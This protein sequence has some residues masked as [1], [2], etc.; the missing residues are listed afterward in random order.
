MREL[1]P[2]LFHWTT[3]HPNIGQEVSS[4]YLT[5]SAALLD[6]MVPADGMAA[7]DGLTTP[8]HVVLSCR[9]H[10]RDHAQFVETFG[11]TFHVNENGTHEYPDEEITAF[12]IGDE[13]VR[14]VTAV[15]NGPIAPDDTVL[16]LDVDGGALLFADSVINARGGPG[17]V[18]DGLLGEDPDQVRADITAAVTELLETQQFEH[19]L[20]AHGDPITGRGREAL[21]A[22][23]QNPS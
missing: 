18:P 9:H 21:S 12:G 4:Y 6:P 8:A 19:V 20:F 13:V 23:V 1:I 10:D 17:F 15:A 14:G 5:G 11:A 22:L 3:E 2:G 16:K 7:F